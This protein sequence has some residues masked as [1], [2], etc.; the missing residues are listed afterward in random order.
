MRY[1]RLDILR[2]VAIILMVIFHLNYSLVHIFNTNILNFSEIFWFLLGKIAAISFIFIAGISFFLAEKKYQKNITKKYIWVSALLWCIAL[3]ISIWTYFLF[4]EEHIRFGIIH[5][6]SLSFLL[7]LFFRKFRYGNIVVWGICIIY[8]TFFIPIID[9]QYWYF[10]WYVY[11]GFR[12]ADYYPVFPYFWVMLCGYSFA[13]FLE[14]YNKFDI[15]VSYKNN[16]ITD[17][18]EWTGKRSLVIYLIHQPIIII[19]FY[20]IV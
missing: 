12:S 2:W 15:L 17:L 16:K 19:L 10:L 13:L 4:P 9:S 14:Y 20:L 18:L 5:F 7:L 3:L 6:F 8:W 11:K 1:K